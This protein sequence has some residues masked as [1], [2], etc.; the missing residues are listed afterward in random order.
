MPSALPLPHPPIPPHCKDLQPFVSPGLCRLNWGLLPW[1]NTLKSRLTCSALSRVIFALT[2][3]SD[4]TAVWNSNCLEIFLWIIKHTCIGQL[5]IF[6]EKERYFPNCYMYDSVFGGCLGMP[7]S[8]LITGRWSWNTSLGS[9]NHKGPYERRAGRLRRK[10]CG[11]RTRGCQE[12]VFKKS[13][14]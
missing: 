14:S 9:I 10:R 2:V 1:F 8:W 11:P 7:S 5:S 6:I 3:A 4:L 12:Q 13:G